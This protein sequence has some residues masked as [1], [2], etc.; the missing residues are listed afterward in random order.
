MIL[1]P[2]T[3]TGWRRNSHRHRL[4]AERAAAL[5]RKI[6][7][8]NQAVQLIWVTVLNDHLALASISLRDRDA[9]T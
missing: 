7:A 6:E 4:I 2:Q 1:R 3:Q 8:L 9:G 5:V